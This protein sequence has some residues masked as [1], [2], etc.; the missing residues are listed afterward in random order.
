MLFPFQRCLLA[1][2]PLHRNYLLSDDHSPVYSVRRKSVE[3]LCLWESFAHAL[4][5]SSL[6]CCGGDPAIQSLWYFL[7]FKKKKQINVS[8]L[9][10]FKW[11]IKC[12]NCCCCLFVFVWCVFQTSCSKEPL[13]SFPALQSYKNYPPLPPQPDLLSSG[14]CLSSVSLDICFP[15]CPTMHWRRSSLTLWLL[16][17]INDRGSGHFITIQGQWPL[18]GSSSPSWEYLT[19]FWELLHPARCRACWS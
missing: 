12:L 15:W 17:D 11:S 8:G 2:I 19:M 10:F 5:N 14:L 13:S 7:H 1:G 3:T 18:C 6:Q 9:F 4:L 16:R